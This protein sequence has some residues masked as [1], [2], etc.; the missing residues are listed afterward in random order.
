MRLHSSACTVILGIQTNLQEG[1]GTSFPR[2]LQEKQNAHQ[3]RNHGPQVMLC[4]Q[5]KMLRYSSV[6]GRVMPLRM[7]MLPL[8]KLSRALLQICMSVNMLVMTQ[9]GKGS[10]SR[11]GRN[12]QGTSERCKPMSGAV[13]ALL[14]VEQCKVHAQG[15][16]ITVL[17]KT[18]HKICQLATLEFR[19]QKLCLPTGHVAYMQ[20]DR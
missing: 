8:C 15:L 17:L 12:M 14:S 20:A 5:S 2:C 9:E 19:P 6:S 18:C 1:G 10:S 7:C 16:Q 4:V 11:P 3:V 13:L